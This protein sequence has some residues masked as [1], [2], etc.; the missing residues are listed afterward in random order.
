MI[1]FADN[2]KMTMVARKRA[3]SSDR[4]VGIVLFD[5]ETKLAKERRMAC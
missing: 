3:V 5:T 4:I 1:Y 2:A